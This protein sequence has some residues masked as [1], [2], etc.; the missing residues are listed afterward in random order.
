M[1]RQLTYKVFSVILALVVLCSTVSFTIDKHFCGDTLVDVSIFFEA[2]KCKMENIDL[3]SQGSLKNQC[4]KDQVNMLVGQDELLFKTFDN[5]NLEQQQFLAN[6]T[7]SYISSLIED[8]QR[9]ISS[10]SYTPPDLRR[11]RVVINQS[12]LI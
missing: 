1:F 4:C 10:R 2:D 6:I 9:I 3:L 7:N 12:F 5:L 11:D 8:E